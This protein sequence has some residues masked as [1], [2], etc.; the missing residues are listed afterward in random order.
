MPLPSV[1][2]LSQLSLHSRT[3]AFCGDVVGLEMIAPSVV[4][5][6][7]E[8]LEDFHDC[9]LCGTLDPMSQFLD[10]GPA[11]SL[12]SGLQPIVPAILTDLRYRTDDLTVV[13][14]WTR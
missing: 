7:D 14:T 13:A 4:A 8:P 9:L 12:E 6:C 5:F 10:C 11:V 3:P 2:L 1:R